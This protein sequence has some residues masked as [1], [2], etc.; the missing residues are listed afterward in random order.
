MILIWECFAQTSQRRDKLSM[1]AKRVEHLQINILVKSLEIVVQM[2]NPLYL[3]RKVK[4]K[5]FTQIQK[6]K[7][8]DK[9]VQPLGTP[10][11]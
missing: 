6:S 7:S 5:I 2:L 4:G 8:R 9:L 3:G 10:S 11:P 1:K